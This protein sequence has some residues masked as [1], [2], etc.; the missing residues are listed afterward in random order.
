MEHIISKY[1]NPIGVC[2]PEQRVAF[3]CPNDSSYVVTQEAVWRNESVAVPLS[4]KH[5]PEMLSYFLKDSAPS[6]LILH[7]DFAH[8]AS[9]SEIANLKIPLHIIEKVDYVPFPTGK[10]RMLTDLRNLHLLAED[11]YFSLMDLSLTRFLCRWIADLGLFFSNES[12]SSN[13]ALSANRPA[14]IVYTSGTT[15]PPKV[16]EKVKKN[17]KSA[18]LTF[19][20][21]HNLFL[22]AFHLLLQA[23]RQ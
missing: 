6:L 3:M 16:N 17:N 9:S 23:H 4:A 8:L 5:T 13:L 12:D 18:L 2:F 14:L 22:L 21:Y 10:S 11:H 1:L 7:E 15:G 20:A 19:F